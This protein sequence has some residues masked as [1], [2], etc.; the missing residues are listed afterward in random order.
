[1]SNVNV[2]IWPRLL[3]QVAQQ[4]AQIYFPCSRLKTAPH[5][6]L[7]AALD[8]GLTH[9]LAEEIGIVTEFLH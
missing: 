5:R 1:M 2:W 3:S 7:K 6:G 9:A 8:C 4:T